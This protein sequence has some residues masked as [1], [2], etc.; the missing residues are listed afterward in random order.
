MFGTRVDGLVSV[1]LGLN[2]KPEPDIF[3]TACDNLG[4]QYNRSVVVEDAVSGVQAG[5]KGNFGLTLGVAREN[6][7][8]ELK[9]NGAD[10]VVT[11]LSEIS[12]DEINNWFARKNV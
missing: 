2:G 9:A 12:L 7:S 4:V 1:Q 5:H 10:L 6:N 8:E 11:D 3:T